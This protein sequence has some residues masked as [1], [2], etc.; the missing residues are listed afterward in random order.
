[1]LW[2]AQ[3]FI[4]QRN[5]KIN[6]TSTSLN[7]RIKKLAHIL[8]NHAEFANQSFHMTINYKEIIKREGI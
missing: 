6:M 2:E 8:A 3:N 4:Y 1:M 5:K 7:D